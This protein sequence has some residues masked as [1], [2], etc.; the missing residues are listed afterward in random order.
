MSID[1]AFDHIGGASAERTVAFRTFTGSCGT[2]CPEAGR[3]GDA[4]LAQGAA[5]EVRH[6]LRF[7]ALFVPTTKRAFGDFFI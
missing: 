5:T 6:G 7:D 4:T 3:T 1:L 2:R